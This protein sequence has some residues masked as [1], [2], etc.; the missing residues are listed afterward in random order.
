MAINTNGEKIVSLL[1]RDFKSLKRDLITF[2]KAY[3]SGS[4]TDFNETSPGMAFLEWSAYVGDGLNFY[5]DQAFNESGDSATQLKNVIAN[6][7]MRGYRPQGKRP[8]VGKL[9]WAIQVPATVNSFG[10]VVPDD[11]YTPLLLKGSQAV[12]TNGKVYETLDDIPFTASIGRSVTGSQ[13][14]STTGIPTFFAIQR[15]VD[16]VAGNTVTENF[17]ITDFQQFRRLDLGQ[18][19]VIEI[20]SVFDSL[21]NE[22]VETEYLAQDWVFTSTTNVNSD[23]D[24]VPYTM[25]LLAAP[26]RFIVDRDIISGISTL[27][28]GSGDGLSFDDELIPNVASYALPLAGRRTFNSFSIDPQNFLKTRSLGLSPHNTTLT[29][30]YR[31]G[32]GNETNAPARSIRQASNANL[33]FSSTGLD[34]LKKGNVE[35][36]IGCLNPV[37]LTGG[38]PE[39]TIREI[40]LNAAA[41]FAAQSRIVTRE[42]AVAR[43][44]SIPSKFGRPEKVFVKPSNSGRY[45]YDVHI[46]SLD[47]NG[48]LSLATSTLKSNLITYLKKF[49]MLTDGINILDAS[50]LD[51]RVHFGIIVSP[52][53]NRSEVLLNCTNI[54]ADYFSQDRSQIGQQIIV[55]D[56]ISVLNNVLGVVSVYELSFTN[57][58]GITDGLVYSNDRFNI[59]N[60]LRDG[61]LICP[62][63][64][65]FQ[66][67]Y[68]N[69]DIVG[70]AR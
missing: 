48:S 62:D 21:G 14:D 9:L 13:F 26:Y 57:V 1:N 29:V 60:N 65:I 4:F 69:K 28:F 10:E 56:V 34:P 17:T 11:S 50:I 54:L 36:S 46:L 7:K 37:S 23:S 25:K 33:S 42:D 2:S 68:P 12:G 32:G 27:I 16:I 61:M 47:S 39:E 15:S 6:A 19:D 51:I 58:M 30:T 3:A 67:K 41:F 49:K 43:I 52:G 8:S 5:I 35:G 38:G 64:S 53:R 31:V 20:I 66:V 63:E 22:W 40:K 55:S 18:V 70:S 59:S 45:A 44:L 24:T